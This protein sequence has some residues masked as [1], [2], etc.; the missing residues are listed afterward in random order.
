VLCRLLVSCTLL[1]AALG[2]RRSSEAPA[3]PA[4]APSTAKPAPGLA[5]PDA[6]AGFAAVGAPVTG[7]GWVRRTY[8]RDDVEVEITLA[9]TALAPG[10]FDSWLAMSRAFPQATLDAPAAD[11]NGFYQCTQRPAPIELPPSCNLLIQLRSGIHVEIRG[12]GF[13]RRADV[14]ALAAALPLRALAAGAP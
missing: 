6:L 2:C 5:L 14:D 11:A 13:S 8:K 10:G 9:Q 1:V 4:P 3:P 12:H 7:P